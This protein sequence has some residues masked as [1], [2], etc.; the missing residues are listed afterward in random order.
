MWV[1]HWQSTAPNMDAQVVNNLTF[2]FL[3]QEEFDQLPEY[4][5]TL[6]STTIIGRKWKCKDDIRWLLGTY[7]NHS[8][9]TKVGIRWEIIWIMQ[10]EKSKV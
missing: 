1:C 7:V 8:D 5:L 6:P 9:P 3:T 4:S 10:N 2:A